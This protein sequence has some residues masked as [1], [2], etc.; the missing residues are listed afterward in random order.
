MVA[1]VFVRAEAAASGEGV[2]LR[3]RFTWQHTNYIRTWLCTVYSFF[4]CHP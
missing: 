3:S 4:A 2:L 1:L